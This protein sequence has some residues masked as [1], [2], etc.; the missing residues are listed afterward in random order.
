MDKK[1]SNIIKS[2][3]QSIV[4]ATINFKN[5]FVKAKSSSHNRVVNDST[6]SSIEKS[7]L[8]NATY[9]EDDYLGHD[10]IDTVNTETKR[11][12]Q[13]AHQYHV[14]LRSKPDFVEQHYSP[15]KRSKSTK[16]LVFNKDTQADATPSLRSPLWWTS[17]KPLTPQQVKS[18]QLGTNTQPMQST[19]TTVDDD[20]HRFTFKKLRDPIL[21]NNN[22]PFKSFGLNSLSD[23][24][25]IVHRPSATENTYQS[26]PASW[27]AQP[28]A[29]PPPPPA[30]PQL[31]SRSN[32]Y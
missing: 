11:A 3:F 27:P 20:D 4:D 26:V 13:P 18:M 28:S 25:A 12:L 14:H 21:S 29:P 24:K 23:I 31:N 2:S 19:L 5:S 22:D 6:R 15:P 16:K 7:A 10:N 32:F 17:S 8:D 9:V 30:I 1:K